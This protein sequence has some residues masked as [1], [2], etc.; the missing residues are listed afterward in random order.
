[1]VTHSKSSH[2]IQYA[3]VAKTEKTASL[4]MTREKLIAEMGLFEE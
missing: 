4:N 2:T 1:L 3:S